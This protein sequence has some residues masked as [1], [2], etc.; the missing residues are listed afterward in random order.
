M[1][2]EKIYPDLEGKDYVFCSGEHVKGAGKASIMARSTAKLQQYYKLFKCPMMGTF[3][4]QLLEGAPDLR[5][6]FLKYGADKYWL[7]R[8][9]GL[10]NSGPGD[11]YAYAVRWDGSRQPPTMLELISKRK[12][13]DSFRKKSLI[14]EIS[15]Q[16]T[17]AEIKKW[18]SN[19][20]SRSKFQGHPWHNNPR[21]DSELLWAKMQTIDYGGRTVLDIGCNTGYFSFR[22]A[23]A[24]AH[25]RGIDTHMGILEIAR[26]INDHIEM[27]D[28]IFSHCDARKFK[29]T[30][31]V[32]FYLSVHHQFDPSHKQLE[33]TIKFLQSRC[34]HLYI[35]L[36]TP[37]LSGTGDPDEIVHRFGGKLIF[38][39]RHRVRRDRSLYLI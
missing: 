8:L 7:V 13:P 23:H 27:T 4:V 5:K 10:Q 38:R 24:G 32:I 28:V 16:W 31:D 17:K 35:E 20:G 2:D 18:D 22:A 25:V 3:N 36:M 14:L 6:P 29:G 19:L 39:Y 9:V 26:D 12:I 1:S 33:K 15:S 21:S 34:I 30:Y 11:F 37:P